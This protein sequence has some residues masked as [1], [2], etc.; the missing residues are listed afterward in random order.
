MNHITLAR[1]NDLI[2]VVPATANLIGKFASGI[3]DDLANF[4]ACN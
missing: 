4:V 2:E 3:A 1:G